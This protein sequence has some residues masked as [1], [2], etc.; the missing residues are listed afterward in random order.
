MAR[1]SGVGKLTLRARNC[2]R[3][4]IDYIVRAVTDTNEA[5]FSDVLEDKLL[6]REYVLPLGSKH[7]WVKGSGCRGVS[8][9][10]Q[11]A[12]MP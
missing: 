10:H 3:Q 1:K 6:E 2:P 11:L 7:Q 9:K 5:R 12:D 8:E 4:R